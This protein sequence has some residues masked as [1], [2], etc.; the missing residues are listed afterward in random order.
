MAEA[1]YWR[2]CNT[3]PLLEVVQQQNP[4]LKYSKDKARCME[5]ATAYI[6]SLLLMAE[7]QS[8]RQPTDSRQIMVRC[9]VTIAHLGQ[10]CGKHERAYVLLWH[11][12]PFGCYSIMHSGVLVCLAIVAYRSLRLCVVETLHS[13]FDPVTVIMSPAQM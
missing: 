6:H 11:W 7:E 4:N 9:W 2:W 8:W 5:T 12:V 1:P 13:D 3:Q 10:G